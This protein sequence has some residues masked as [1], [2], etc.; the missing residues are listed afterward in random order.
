VATGDPDREAAAAAWTLHATDFAANRDTN[1]AGGWVPTRPEVIEQDPY[2]ANDP[3]MTTTLDALNTG[4]Y[5]VPFWP[6]YPI[7]QNAINV[8]V[9]AAAS[10]Q[11]TIDEA[12]DAAQAEVEREVAARS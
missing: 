11:Q 7:L 8:A 2:Y 10:G 1:K 4:G 9:Q 12:L 6:I 3:F 5:V